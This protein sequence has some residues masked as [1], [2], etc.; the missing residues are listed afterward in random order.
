MIVNSN[1]VV[2]CEFTNYHKCEKDYSWNPCT[3]I[4]ENSR[5]L[6]SVADTSVTGRD[7]I[8]TVMDN[9]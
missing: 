2:Q 7:E 4:C 3:C 5:Y 6:K 1:S 8:V 9:L